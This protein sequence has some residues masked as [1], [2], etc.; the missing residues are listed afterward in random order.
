M[1]AIPTVTMNPSID[2]FALTG[3]VVPIRKLRCTDVRRDPGG[4]INVARVVKRLGRHCRAIYPAG[5][6]AV[7]EDSYA[8][9]ARIAASIRARIVLDTSGP[10]RAAAFE[11]GAHLVK[12]SVRELGD[13][14]AI[15][16]HAPP[17]TPLS[18]YR[19]RT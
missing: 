6:L 9:L 15:R 7:P 11:A 19:R 13:P 18:T 3:K 5:G 4:G 10:I 12:P 8:R 17:P 14:T 2:V 1:T 16:R